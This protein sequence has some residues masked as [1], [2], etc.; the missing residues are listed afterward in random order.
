MN[1]SVI[2]EFKALTQR[3]IAI[4][5]KIYGYCSNFIV[6]YTKKKWSYDT[7]GM[8]CLQNVTQNSS[9]VKLYSICVCVCVFNER[10]ANGKWP[11]FVK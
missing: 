7:G 3:I 6:V 8:G 4:R 9:P 11:L 10:L 5:Y 2:V 1:Y